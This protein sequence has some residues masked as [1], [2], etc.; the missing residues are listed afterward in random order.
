MGCSFERKKN[1]ATTNDLQK[2]LD[3]SNRKLNKIWEDS[4]RNVQ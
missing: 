1:I 4:G 2:T 3:E